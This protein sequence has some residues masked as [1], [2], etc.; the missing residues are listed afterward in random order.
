M[1]KDILNQVIEVGD[2]VAYPSQTR[3][4]LRMGTAVV[5]SIISDSAIRLQKTRQD[6]SDYNWVYTNL[7]RLVVTKGQ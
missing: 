1:L 2:T 6:G 3:Q 7:E 4:G 5:T